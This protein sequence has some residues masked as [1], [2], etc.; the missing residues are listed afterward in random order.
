MFNQTSLQ[1]LNDDDLMYLLSSTYMQQYLLQQMHSSIYD[2][3]LAQILEFGART[4]MR[5]CMM[6]VLFTFSQ[7]A[8]T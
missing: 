6:F 3:P 7:L 2:T 5:V 8:T 1:K 4:S